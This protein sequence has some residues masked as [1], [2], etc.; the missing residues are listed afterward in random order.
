MITYIQ[1]QEP[2]GNLR[3]GWGAPEERKRGRGEKEGTLAKR[4]GF[5]CLEHGKNI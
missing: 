2:K 5:D 4:D 1:E 3:V